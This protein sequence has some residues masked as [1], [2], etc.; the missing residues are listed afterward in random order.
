MKYESVHP[1]PKIE[2]CF[3]M[4]SLSVAFLQVNLCGMFCVSPHDESC[5]KRG[6]WCPVVVLTSPDYEEAELL[7]KLARGDITF[8]HFQINARDESVV[9]S[10][11]ATSEQRCRIAKPSPILSDCNR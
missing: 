4:T 5:F 9:A 11:Y 6:T 7:V 2:P 8:C 3:L 1:S 10:P